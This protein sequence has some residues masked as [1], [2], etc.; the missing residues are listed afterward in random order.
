MKPDNRNSTLSHPALAVLSLIF[1][2]VLAFLY[3]AKTAS[4]P[5]AATSVQTTQVVATATSV[6][7]ALLEK[8]PF[9]YAAPLPDPVPSPLDGI[10]AKVDQSWPQWWLCRRCADYRP[11]GGIWRLQF[12]KGVMRIYYEVTGWISMASFT[13]SGDRLHIFTRPYCPEDAGEYT[14]KLE[15]GQLTLETI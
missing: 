12:D 14:W 1:V 6:W 9:A 10:Y 4:I 8:T 5:A 15:D 13:V 7:D 11:A 2:S 3:S